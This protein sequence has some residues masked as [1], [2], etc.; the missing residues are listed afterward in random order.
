M[1]H[2]AM[3]WQQYCTA[4][5]FRAEL[6]SHVVYSE[7]RGCDYQHLITPTAFWIDSCVSEAPPTVSCSV[8][9]RERRRGKGEF[10]SVKDRYLFCLEI[11]I[12]GTDSV[13]NFHI[14]SDQT[15]KFCTATDLLY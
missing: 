4:P 2:P 9:E 6:S 12:S 15:E 7:I 5:T 1:R 10:D 3:G 13:Q 11:Q 8:R 14:D